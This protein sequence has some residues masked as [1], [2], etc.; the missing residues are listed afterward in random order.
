[1]GQKVK[2][3]F[4]GA[5]VFALL[6][7][8]LLL[9]NTQGSGYEVIPLKE[10]YGEVKN[11]LDAKYKPIIRLKNKNSTFCTG[12]VIDGSYAIT[13]AHCLV[14]K[15]GFLTKKEIQVFSDIDEDTKVT[16]VAAGI[17]TRLDQGLIKGDFTNFIPMPIAAEVDGFMV[18][19]HLVS[20]GFPS[21]QKRI[22]CTPFIVQKREVFETLGLGTVYPA[23]SGG[24]IFE[25]ETGVAVG[26]NTA[27]SEEGLAVGNSIIGIL[28]AFGIENDKQD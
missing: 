7:V 23:M 6:L 22:F 4:I 18:A 16:A 26:L 15:D 28:G 1:M 12:F 19:P 9:A 3:A 2:Y 17:Y 10:K 27:S 25:Q 14:D 24:P 20:C 5:F 21:G 8:G 13:A 11:K